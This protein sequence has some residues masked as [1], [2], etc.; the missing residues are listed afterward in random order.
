MLL[1][2]SVATVKWDIPDSTPEGT[3]RLTHTGHFKNMVFG[4]NQY[5]GASQPFEVISRPFDET[6]NE[7][8]EDPH[9]RTSGSGTPKPWW[10]RIFGF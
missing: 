8:P 4:L 7:R 6:V 1:G 10:L 3:Y 2:T 5:Y 9:M